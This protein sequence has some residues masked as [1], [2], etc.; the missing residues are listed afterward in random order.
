VGD[1]KSD[2]PMDVAM[3]MATEATSIPVETVGSMKNE[4]MERY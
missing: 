1:G 3:E 2:A 4:P